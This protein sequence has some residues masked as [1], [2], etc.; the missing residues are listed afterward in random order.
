MENISD[1]S[2]LNFG[3]HTEE[4]QYNGKRYILTYFKLEFPNQKVSNNFQFIRWKKKLLQYYDLVVECPKCHCY[5]PTLFT[6]LT[7]CA[8]CGVRFCLECRRLHCDGEC[9]LFC[10]KVLKFYGLKEFKDHNLIENIWIFFIT[11]SKLLFCFP[12]VFAYKYFP[13]Y[14]SKKNNH[15]NNELIIDVESYKKKGWRIVFV[16]FPYQVSFFWFWLYGM[17]FMY[18]VPGMCFPPFPVFSIGILRYV[19][20]NTQGGKL[21]ELEGGESLAILSESFDDK[22]KNLILNY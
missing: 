1:I 16:L 21:I 3:P 13:K 8:A 14:I 5:Y 19:E 2:K 22:D 12:L 4:H 7:V 10:S 20:K 18:L 9:K 17:L 11:L 15:D 6:E